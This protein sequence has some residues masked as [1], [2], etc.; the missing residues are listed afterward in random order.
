MLAFL[1]VF[2]DG[3]GPVVA[4]LMNYIDEVGD[5]LSVRGTRIPRSE[6]IYRLLA[7]VIALQGAIGP[8][9]D[10]VRDDWLRGADWCGM[11]DEVQNGLRNVLDHAIRVTQRVAGAPG[12]CSR[13]R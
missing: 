9:S 13:T 10:M 5:S 7:Q 2:V 6:R 4:G 12:P 8:L 11:G 1:D 3:S